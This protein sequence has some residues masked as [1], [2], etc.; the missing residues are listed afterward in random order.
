ME[1]QD[2][3]ARYLIVSGQP[4]LQPD[5]SQEKIGYV[6][7]RFEEEEGD[8]IM[9]IMEVQ[10]APPCQGK[11]LGRFLV[12]L[13]EL[14]A[15]RSGLAKMML[16]VMHANMAGQALY[17]RLGFVLDDSSPSRHDPLSRAGYDIMSKLIVPKG[18]RK[19]S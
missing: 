8:P 11:G 14:I 1:L 7:W 3:A 18:I 9:Y 2:P 19:R 6:H 17:R 5:L 15:R 4:G 12:Q 13:L 16:T 10:L